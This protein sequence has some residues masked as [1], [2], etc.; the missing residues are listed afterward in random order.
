[1]PPFRYRLIVWTFAIG[2]MALTCLPYLLA[3]NATPDGQVYDGFLV[4]AE[5]GRSYVGKMRLGLR[6]EWNFHLFYT[7]EDHDSAPLLFLPYIGAGQAV[8]LIPSAGTGALLWAYHIMRVIF[9]LAVIVVTA[10]FI[11]R[12]LAH[13][14]LL[15][16]VL[17]TLGG[18]LGVILFA[19]GQTPPEFYI[20]EA[21]SFLALFS[22]PHL[23]LARAAMLG[24][25][26]L[27]L[28]SASVRGRAVWAGALW[29]ITGLAVPFYLAILYALL[30]VWGLLVWARGRRFPLQL[31]WRCLVAAGVT[32]PLFGYNLWVFSANAAF[33]QWSA[34]NILPAP[35]VWHYALAYLPYLIFAAWGVRQAWRSGNERALLMVAWAAC[36]LVLVYLPISIQRR[37]AEGVLLPLVILAL[38]GIQA[39][40]PVRDF[41]RIALLALALPTTLFFYVGMLAVA[42]TGSNST[43][44]TSSAL[45]D[46]L[47]W[48]Q[49]ESPVTERGAVILADYESGNRI[50]MVSDLRTYVGHGPE[51]LDSERKK[52]EVAAYFADTL[53][54]AARA[55]LYPHADYVLFNTPPPAWANNELTAVYAPGGIFVYRVV[56]P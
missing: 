35:P 52:V 32:L 43:L 36:G 47:G 25:L 41:R 14:Q 56:R 54:P 1:M 12:T 8:R 45:I 17:V 10:D 49:T 44:Y 21:F 31:F 23:L 22:L 50:P 29:W 46:A 6:G 33:A 16:L 30:G 24:G 55:A 27:L 18:G 19:F 5:D 42:P 4:G 13:D 3:W 37:L 40:T 11:R 39:S 48:I 53:T 9:G 34:Q 2:V 51:T 20:P 7:D 38:W 26:M 28:S 15:A